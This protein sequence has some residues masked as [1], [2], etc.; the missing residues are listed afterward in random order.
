MKLNISPD[1]RAELLSRLRSAYADEFDDSLSDFRA[2]VL[3]DLVMGAVG[4]AIYNQAVKDAQAFMQSRLD[5]LDGEVRVSE[6]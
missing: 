2:K 3:L 5:D 6:D 1:R 4:P